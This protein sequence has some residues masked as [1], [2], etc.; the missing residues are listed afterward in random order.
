M[1]IVGIDFASQSSFDATLFDEVLFLSDS[2]GALIDKLNKLSGS[3]SM[4]RSTSQLSQREI[5]VLKLVALGQSNK[6]ISE[7]LF[8]SIH[9]VITHR[10]H[11]T[12]RLGVKSISGLT[13]YAVINH[14][15]D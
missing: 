4:K 8:I 7:K 9:T 1:L 10:K 3:V 6:Q 12:A 5:E 13:L 14:L 15:I 11:I 2:Q